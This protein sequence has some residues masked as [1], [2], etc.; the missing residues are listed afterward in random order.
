MPPWPSARLSVAQLRAG[1]ATA[2]AKLAAT[3]T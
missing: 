1:Y 3:G 2:Q